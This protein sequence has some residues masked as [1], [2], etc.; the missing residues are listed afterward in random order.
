MARNHNP[1]TERQLNLL[2]VLRDRLSEITDPEPQIIT[3]EDFEWHRVSTKE[4]GRIPK[5]RFQPSST[6]IKADLVQQAGLINKEREKEA[7]EIRMKYGIRET[8]NR[9]ARLFE[10]E[11]NNIMIKAKKAVLTLALLNNDFATQGQTLSELI[12]ILQDIVMEENASQI[13]APKRP[14]YSSETPGPAETPE[15][16][17][18]KPYDQELAEL[19]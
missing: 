7:G 1:F 8:K 15:F 19:E 11:W 3:H 2:K 14:I 5:I 16:K 17:G 4:F 6:R 9:H 12:R 10:S 18:I 13:K